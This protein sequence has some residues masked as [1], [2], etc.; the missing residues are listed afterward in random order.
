MDARIQ[1]IGLRIREARRRVGI[2]HERLARR[3]D[4]SKQTVINV[5]F[6]RSDLRLSTL[7]RL[8]DAL[9]VDPAYFLNGPGP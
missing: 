5:E 3:L 7:L 2:S 1:V 9:G 6:G 8:A 4:M